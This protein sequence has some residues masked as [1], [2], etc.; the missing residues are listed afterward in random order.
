M[1]TV[2]VVAFAA[3]AVGRQWRD[4]GGRVLALHVDWLV[5]AAASLVVLATYTVLIETWRRVLA[6]WDT[7]LDWWTATGVWFVSGLARYI[8][9][10]IWSIAAIGAMA[11]RRGASAVAAAGS[12]I[13]I[14][15]INVASGAAIVLL[16]GARLVPQPGAV[17]V[18]AALVL[19]GGAAAP[20][21]VRP[22]VAW[23]ARA[24]G[25]DVRLPD[26][27]AST[28][29]IALA[30][31]S[32]A[33]IGYGAAF[34]LF[35][36]SILGA[37][38]L[39]GELGLYI[40]AYTAAYILGFVTPVAPA[41]I[42]VREFGIIE[43]MS[44]LGLATAGDAALVAVASRLWLTVLEAAPGVFALALIHARRRPRAA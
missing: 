19:L 11:R 15:V 18:V 38:A 26:L 21:L 4:V 34:R 37:H 23:T 5:L 13:L 22:A 2:A 33:W 41:G 9:G 32:L 3:V 42:G 20:R 39:Q 27:P 24:L 14:N 35:A 8:P 7:R 6:V 28:V 1:F 10:N 16:F 12:S 44:R 40:A 31:T 29:W 30:G 17:A 36:G 25:R 43:G